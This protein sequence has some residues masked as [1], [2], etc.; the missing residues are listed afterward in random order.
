VG[1]GSMKRWSHSRGPGARGAGG[2]RVG[3]RPLPPRPPPTTSLPHPASPRGSHG[4]DGCA[5][6]GLKQGHKGKHIY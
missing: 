4:V 1:Q 6:P 5:T 2:A 3:Q